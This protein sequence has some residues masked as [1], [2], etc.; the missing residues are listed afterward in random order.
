VG[1]GEHRPGDRV[2]GDG[3]S[4]RLVTDRVLD[5]VV[6]VAEAL[7][8]ADLRTTGRALP[9]PEYGILPVHRQ[10]DL[11]AVGPVGEVATHLEEDVP[12]GHGVGP[13]GERLEGHVPRRGGGDGGH[14]LGELL[15]HRPAEGLGRRVDGARVVGVVTA[16]GRHRHQGDE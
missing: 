5:E 7:E 14:P 9:G 2:V 16:A 15:D 1:P 12:A 4:R 10:G 11:A 8:Q 13:G 3:Q 6:A